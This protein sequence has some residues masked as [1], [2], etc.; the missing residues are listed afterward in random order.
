MII[1]IASFN[2][3]GLLT[4]KLI[5]KNKEY[6]IRRI[7]GGSKLSFILDFMTENTI[8]TGV[9]FGISFLLMQEMI[10]F[11]N[12]LTG[13]NIT[14]KYLLQT[15]QISSLFGI[16]FF[17]L[18]ITLLY[19]IFRIQSDISPS[20]LKSDHNQKDN[21]VQ[22]PAFN[23]LQL[24]SSIGLIFCSMVIIKQMTFIN[25]KPIGL[26][27]KVIEVRLPG[28]HADRVTVFKEELMKKTSID[29]VSVVGTSPVLEH[30]LLILKYEDGGV[31]KQYSPAGF[32]GDE[33]YLTTLGI[34]LIEGFGFSD[35]PTSNNNKCLVNE[36]FAKFFTG[37]SLIG[38]SMPGMDDKIIAG[39]VKDFHYSGL[40]S[41]IEPAF[42]SFDNKGSHLMVKA[43]DNQ[44]DQAKDAITMIWQNLIPDYPVNIESVGDRFEWFHRENKNYI[45][46]IGA[47]A[48]I[49]LFLSMI[50]LFAISFQI[51]RYRTKEIGIRKINGAR[52]TDMIIMLNNDFVKWLAIAFIIAAPISWFAM[53]KWLQNFAYRTDISLWVY[54]ATGIIALVIVLL[55]VSWQS[56]RSATRNPVE[57]LRYE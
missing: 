54:V 35:N 28:Q 48:F 19:A 37:Q 46:L 27:K 52:I 16:V 33:N 38:K 12:E 53:H 31:E 6:N 2:Y 51:S 7:H 20:L 47:C 24:S 1:G 10:P 30:F 15:E 13:S 55:T 41:F 21:R 14:E 23:I 36:S 11:F 50:G 57:T 49:S 39:I 22:F 32:S 17:L 9:S 34:E 56:W 25:D 29:Q 5:E 26:N 45:R 3:L 42:I 4:N 43:T 40:K 44:I 18:L 8:L